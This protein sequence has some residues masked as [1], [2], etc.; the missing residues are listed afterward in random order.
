VVEVEASKLKTPRKIDAADALGR[1]RLISPRL[2]EDV[3]T[4]ALSHD[5]MEAANNT[6]PKGL[7]G[8]YTPFSSTYSAGQN[9][10]SLKVAMDLAR[11]FDLS[12]GHPADA[13]DKASILVLA[14][15]LT[16]PDIQNGLLQ[17]AAKR[18]AGIK[19]GYTAG[20]PPPD[21][22]EADLESIKDGYR[23][24]DV[25]ACQKAITDFLSL[26]QS[27]AKDSEKNAALVRIRQF[28]T[29]RLAH[30]LFDKEPDA[31]PKYADLELLLSIAKEA[32]KNASFAVEGHNVD[33]DD[34]AQ[35]DRKN[36]DNY[37]ACVLD[38]LKRAARRRPRGAGG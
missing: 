37:Y 20:S 3:G 10:L 2:R 26:A 9:A 36:A 7:A 14:A 24:R 38:G 4:A 11:I 1:V 19:I 25:D 22:L 18:I 27:L 33:F 8:I 35:E 15:L 34:M 13:Q 23:S 17:D 6:I 29:R 21:V 28:R 12:D 16:R 5:V 31:L 32:T 30:F